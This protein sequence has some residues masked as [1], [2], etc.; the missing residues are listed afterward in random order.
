VAASVTAASATSLTVTVPALNCQPARP[1]TVQVTVG[2]SASNKF[3]HPRRPAS[4]V[5]LAV[6]Q[7][8]IVSSPSD[9]CLQF[10]RA[11][12]SETYV[13]GVQ[14]TSETPS[15]LTP[16]TVTSVV[17]PGGAPSPP[18]LAAARLALQRSAQPTP[19]ALPRGVLDR[20]ARLSRHS[21]AHL[22]LREREEHRLTG[23]HRQAMRLAMS[24]GVQ[25]AIP[26]AVNV[27]DSVDVKVPNINSDFCA[28]FIQVRTVVRAGTSSTLNPASRVCLT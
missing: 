7:Q 1:D 27:G 21:Q 15:S 3:V 6:G 20:M 12:A 24:Q 11:A 8:M 16:I 22:R 28:N 17:A 14:S 4:L 9:L 19:R 25:G 10:D 18:A 23:I 5:S 26:P 2:A 13:I